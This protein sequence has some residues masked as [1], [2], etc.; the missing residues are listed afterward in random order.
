MSM[1]LTDDGSM[2]R[3]GTAT[4]CKGTHAGMICSVK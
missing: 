1:T 4:A 2:D 3:F